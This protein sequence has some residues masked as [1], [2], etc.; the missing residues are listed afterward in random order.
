VAGVNDDRYLFQK[1]SAETRGRPQGDGAPLA[2]EAHGMTGIAY[3]IPKPVFDPRPRGPG[4]RGWEHRDP[5]YPPSQSLKT[6]LRLTAYHEAGH[7]LSHVEF[8]I[9]IVKVWLSDPKTGCGRVFGGVGLG[10][11][12]Q[13]AVD[14]LTGPVAERRFA[15]NSRWELSAGLEGWAHRRSLIMKNSDL[16][17]FRY[18]VDLMVG[19]YVGNWRQRRDIITEKM[20]DRAVALVNAHWFEIKTIAA[21][22]LEREILTEAEIY[23]L[24]ERPL[25]KRGSYARER[26]QPKRRRRRGSA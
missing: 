12:E 4:D 15:P 24:L 22:L 10:T 20:E 9:Q 14:S 26:Y 2:A 8:N 18:Y 6:F 1:A 23:Q 7:I 17:S 21:A 19:D 5:F 16:D 3:Q 11:P 25:P 13:E